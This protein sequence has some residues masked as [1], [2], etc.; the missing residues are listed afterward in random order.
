[1]FHA[2]KASFHQQHHDIAA[3]QEIC[4]AAADDVEIR[5]V[6]LVN[7]DDRHRVVDLTTYAEPV[8][9]PHAA[10]ELHPAFSRLFVGS[11][12]L[13]DMDA[14]L[15][16]R[17]SRRPE[18]SP[19]VMLHRLLC[20]D[21]S[22][23]PAGIETDKRA[24]VGRH[25]TYL[26][27]AN[28]DMTGAAGW[29]LDPVAALRTRVSLAPGQRATFAYLTIAAGSWQAA[30]DMAE[31]YATVAA[32]DWALEDAA[33]AAPVEANRVDLSQS[34]MVDAQ[35]LATRLRGPPQTERPGDRGSLTCGGLAF[36]VITR[37]CLSASQMQTA[38]TCSRPSCVRSV[39]SGEM[40][41]GPIL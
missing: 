8:L 22:V 16:T 9:T 13:P 3:T 31:R 29:T 11:E 12:I 30:I 35:H 37:L 2:E 5:R 26:A 6:T 24:L 15:F 41:C 14:A 23:V 38:P 19:P 28:A 21:R 36:L 4:V 25:G 1:M 20:E 39:G 33:R 17:C 40:A 32:L 10:H 18:E 27:A 7:H 34:D